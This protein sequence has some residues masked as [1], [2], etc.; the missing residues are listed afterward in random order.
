MSLTFAA[1]TCLASA[2]APPIALPLALVRAPQEGIGQVVDD[3]V[4]ILKLRIGDLEDFVSHPKDAGL[5]AALGM[6]QARVS[7]LEAQVPFMPPEAAMLLSE[8]VFPV[9]LETLTARK[10]ITV[11]LSPSMLEA[12][13]A[14]VAMGLMLED[15]SPEAAEARMGRIAALAEMMGFPLPPGLLAVKGSDVHGTFGIEAS[16]D[17]AI[18]AAALLPPGSKTMAVELDVAQLLSLVQD[19]TADNLD[20]ED[21]ASTIDMV[22]KFISSTNVQMAWAN[23]GQKT[24][25]VQLSRGA[26]DGLQ[27]FGFYGGE[28]LKPGDLLA[29]PAD[30]TMA[31]VVRVDMKTAFESLNSMIAEMAE[32]QGEDFDLQE[33][34]QGAIDLDLTEE[35]FGKLG[36]LAGF[37]SSQSTGGGGITSGVLFASVKDA[38][39]LRESL[40]KAA[41]GLNGLAGIY[42]QNF[43][44][45]RPWTSGGVEYTTLMFPGLPVPLELTMAVGDSMLV[46]AMTPQAAMAA[47]AQ[48]SNTG[49]TSLAT[50]P[51]LSSGFTEN[52]V[53]LTYVDNAH[54]AR[55]GYGLTCLM[56]GAVSNAMRSTTDPDR[57]PGP[58]VPSYG[59]FMAGIAPTVG[60]LERRGKDVVAFSSGDGSLLVQTAAASGIMQP[61]FALYMLP[62]AAWLGS[63]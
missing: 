25:A 61:I 48:L 12:N 10:S 46:A 50:H 54:F 34:A 38:E 30:A 18:E 39:G 56:M 13:G 8:D 6:L 35:F 26:L 32:E 28:P 21:I 17:V 2:P 60:Y 51:A 59:A 33:F 62:I 3:A 40:E 15:S 16:R 11:G 53:G 49:V 36:D 42:A 1:L 19:L 23:D 47:M 44:S 58:I 63:L 43:V 29:I 14:P 55:E 41:E 52:T 24:H 27:Q 37:Y 9:L 57:D 7:E 22:T 20:A 31:Q 4:P 45:I 5:K